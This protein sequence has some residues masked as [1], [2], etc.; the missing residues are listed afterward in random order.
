MST[1]YLNAETSPNQTV[2]NMASTLLNRI[3]S[4]IA[5][6]GRSLVRLP[7]DPD[8]K[9]RAIHLASELLSERGEATSAARAAALIA[10]YAE[11]SPADRHEF[12]LHLAR[13]FLPPPDRLAAA[14]KAYLEQPS[15][16]TVSELTLAAEPSRRE[17]IRRMNIAPGATALLVAMREAL[18]EALP[19]T[20]ELKPLEQ[21][22]HH[23]LTSWFNPGFLE[24][25]RIDWDTSASIL[26]KLIAYEAVHEIHGWDDLRRRLGPAHRC[27]GFFHPA[28]PDEPLIFVEVALC[29]GLASKI[30]PLLAENRDA[31][32]SDADAAIFYS[33]NNCQPGLRQISF[34]NFLIKYVVEDLGRELPG[35]KLFSTLSPIP[36]L[37]RWLERR[38]QAEDETV[39]L[40]YERA[41]LGE[42]ALEG[43]RAALT[44]LRFE[45]E[46]SPV[47][48]AILERLCAVYLTSSTDKRGP[49]DPVARFH[50]RNG[51]RIER[52]DW[53][54]N[55]APRGLTESFGMMVNYRY[56]T[57]SIEANHEKFVTEG[58]VAMSPEVA[59]LLKPN[60]KRFPKPALAR[61]AE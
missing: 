49:E 4:V 30:A 2:S 33:I 57:G 21:D 22:L 28:L 47:L 43:L 31:K 3:W 37:R 61:A 18:L 41:A 42:P 10:L 35:L 17:L 45:D 25:R 15:A 39:L 13:D 9:I 34:G 20:P 44:A 11:L 60:A 14:A 55:L 50:L 24:L 16:E 51:A 27:Y 46:E 29:V 12:H 36:G 8:P 1:S 32:A 6:S 19:A 59:Q 56:D 5:E 53:A 26:E 23:L 48:K 54:A 52:I 58:K 38:L 7:N 40:D